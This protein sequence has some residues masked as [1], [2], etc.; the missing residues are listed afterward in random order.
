MNKFHPSERNN[1]VELDGKVDFIQRNRTAIKLSDGPKILVCVPIGG[2]AY[3][4]ILPCPVC[5]NDKGEPVKYQVS[6]GFA[7]GGLVPLQFMLSTQNWLPPLNVTMAWTY[8]T[9]V[10]SAQARQIMTQEAKRIGTVE[11]VFYV[12][13]DTLIPPMGLYTL[14]NFMETHPEAGAVSGI[15]T[16]RQKPAEPLI[17][18]KHGRGAAWDIEMG[19]GANPTPI[20]GAGA[21]CLLAR[22]EAIVDW[23]KENSNTPIWCDSSEVVQGTGSRIT[24]GHDVRFVRNLVEAG[25]PCYADGRVLCGHFDIPTGQIF[26]VPAN[27]PGLRKRAV[28]TET[29]WDMV[30][31]SEGINS[32]RTY[33]KMFTKIDQQIAKHKIQDVY[34]LGCGSGVLGQRLTAKHGVHWFGMDFSEVAVAQAKARYLTAVHGDVRDVDPGMFINSENDAVIATELLEHLPWEDA[35]VLLE[36]INAGTA[37]I[38]IFGTPFNTLPPEEEKEH[39]VLVDQEYQDAVKKVMAN[40]KLDTFEVVDDQGHAVWVFVKKAVKRKRKKA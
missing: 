2:K 25:W 35:K 23:E 27:A 20:M 4:N 5:K 28:N 10:L 26:E 38:V 15:Y 40:Y 30:Y 39:E 31:S 14:Y 19:E 21:G 7:T 29:Y 37:N 22:V 8:K 36:K 18:T 33:E 13:D 24:W 34:E 16:T 12:D 32:W 17:Y 11:Y 6:E 1:A 9:G 3:N